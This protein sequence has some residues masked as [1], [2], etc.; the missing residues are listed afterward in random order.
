MIGV[1]DPSNKRRRQLY[2]SASLGVN[3]GTLAIFKYFN[4]FNAS[5]ASLFGAVGIPYQISPLEVLLPVGISFYTF[6][7]MAYTID[8]YRGLKPEKH[9]GMFATY[10]AFFPQLVA[11]PIERAGHLLPQFREKHFFDYQ[12]T[13]EGLQWILWG[14]FKK[15]VIADR[16]AI[17]VNSIY[18]NL[19]EF[20]GLPLI[21]AT[22]FF[23]F[24]I[25]CDF[26][27][28]SDIAIGTAH[29]L[30]F[31]LME[32]FRQPYLATSLRDFWRRWH[33][34]LSTWFKD[35]LYIP[36]GGSRVSFSRNLIN[37]MIVF[38]ISGLWHGANWTFVIW[39]A[40]HGLYIIVE[41]IL[42]RRSRVSVKLPKLASGLLVF[43]F[44]CFAWIFFR[45]NSLD[46]AVYVLQNLFDFSS[47]TRRVTVPFGNTLLTPR[48]EFVV[49]CLLIGFLLL[50]DWGCSRV[51]LL[52]LLRRR[53]LAVRWAVYYA[54]AGAIILSLF[55]T[56]LS[57]TFIY[58]QF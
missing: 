40:L 30:G 12:R 56:G 45:A 46:D 28:Y 57:Q 33:I 55:Y 10:V 20:T 26:S 36:L 53:A 5:A 49:S 13:V 23:A 17:Y 34:S 11:G 8:V 18:N 38:V 19:E 44:V 31:R 3:L 4:F 9:A 22:V 6:Q 1:T 51:G 39:G 50:V 32:N 25:Y 37:L 2:L 24:Q 21:I 47:G 16:L 7:S 15:M 48:M 52:E 27:G 35:Y 58:F 41:T 42:A 14:V 54:L 29:I 43:G